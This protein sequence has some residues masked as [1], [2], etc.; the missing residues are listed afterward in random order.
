MGTTFTITVWADDEAVA[1]AA[2][3]EA[4]ARAA[5][6]NRIMSDYL[7]SSELMKLCA[8][9]GGPAV[10]VSPELFSV[11]ER[12]RRVSEETDGAFDVTVG[13][14]V[15]LW[16]K[17][18]KSIRLPEREA[19]EK[20]RALT[21]WRMMTLD[22]RERKVRLEKAG[23]LLDLGGIAKGYTADEMLAVLKKHGLPRALVA[24][25][26][27]LRLGEP[28]PG[29]DGWAI[30]I[31][32]VAPGEKPHRLTL[33]ECAISTS[34]DASQFVEID[35]VRYS[36]ILDP[37]TGKPLTVRMSAT[38]L[39]PDGITADSL[40]KAVAVLGPEKGFAVL[41]KYRGASGRHVQLTDGKATVTTSPGFPK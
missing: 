26:G 4:F 9:A 34:G 14:I 3:R 20:A 2:A 17:A 21:G 5:N 40:T 31:D 38:V 16:R 7:P 36:H 41:K 35:G 6:L 19:L 37:R 39:A 23:M 8:G 15:R 25:G 11:L 33:K 28:P 30:D 18:R 1:R 12:A 10:Q 22:P 13:P 27:D 24:C 29:K 32:P